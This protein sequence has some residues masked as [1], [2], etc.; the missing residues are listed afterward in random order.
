MDDARSEAA[1]DVHW[2][3]RV[4]VPAA[5]VSAATARPDGRPAAN[6]YL[7]AVCVPREQRDR[8]I[9]GLCRSRRRILA[10][11]LGPQYVSVNWTVSKDDLPGCPRLD[12]GERTRCVWLAAD[13]IVEADERERPA[14]GIARNGAIYEKLYIVS[15]IQRIERA[16]IDT[17]P[18]L[19]IAE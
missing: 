18:V 12:L 7:A 8:A 16:E 14:V 19:P 5:H 2:N 9:P 3:F 15:S 11:R 10:R 6:T 17:T 13:Q 1:G 4:A